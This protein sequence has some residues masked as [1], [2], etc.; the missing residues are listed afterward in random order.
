MSPRHP[1]QHVESTSRLFNLSTLSKKQA[2][3]AARRTVPLMEK[4]ESAAQIAT[5]TNKAKVLTAA[6][7]KAAYLTAEKLVELEPAASFYVISCDGTQLLSTH[8]SYK[9]ATTAIE[10]TCDIVVWHPTLAAG[11]TPAPFKRCDAATTWKNDH[12]NPATIPLGNPRTQRS[13]KA[14]DANS[15]DVGARV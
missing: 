5:R 11:Y 3:I 8:G 6:Q 4:P 10:G 2:E 13:N 14:V 1:N 15:G 9:E 12:K 7:L